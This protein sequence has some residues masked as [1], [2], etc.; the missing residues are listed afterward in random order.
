MPRT[1]QECRSNNG[2]QPIKVQSASD[3][4][5]HHIVLCASWITP[6]EYICDCTGYQF[7]NHCRHQSKAAKQF[8]RWSEQDGPE[9]Q[10][11]AQR[12]TRTCPRCGG[13]TWKV[14]ADD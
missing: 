4:D 12:K 7:R 11:D 13:L 3:P 8:C 9:E 10:T 14:M 5:T 6:F 2:W 1:I